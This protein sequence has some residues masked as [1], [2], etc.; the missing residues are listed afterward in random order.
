MNC[1]LFTP[2][3]GRGQ[4]KPLQAVVLSVDTALGSGR[5]HFDMVSA[6]LRQSLRSLSKSAGQYQ[7]RRFAGNLPVKQNKYVEDWATRR[8]LIEQEF[9]WDAK[10]VSTV[11]AFGLVVPYGVYSITYVGGWGW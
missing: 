1:I 10:T 9:K 4:P 5:N 8:E 2:R 7:Q 3:V 11:L 6:V